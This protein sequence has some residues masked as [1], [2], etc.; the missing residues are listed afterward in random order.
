MLACGALGLEES[1]FYFVSRLSFSSL[2]KG[3]PLNYLTFIITSRETTFIPSLVD[4]S[5]IKQQTWLFWSCECEKTKIDLK[6]ML[7]L[8][9]NKLNETWLELNYIEFNKIILNWEQNNRQY[10]EHFLPNLFLT[11]EQDLTLKI[12]PNHRNFLK[13]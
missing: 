9:L 3:R 6:T 4:F 11:L 8:K 12:S 10:Y 7:K 13:R 5:L 1:K 2:F